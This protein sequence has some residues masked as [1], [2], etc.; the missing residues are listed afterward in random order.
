MIGYSDADFA[1]S[2]DSRKSTFGYIFKLADGAVSWRSVKQ[3]LT[4]TS[5]MEA[6]FVFC[7]E[8]SSHG[9]WL[10][11]FISGLS[12]TPQTRGSVDYPSTRGIQ[13]KVGLPDATLENR[14]ESP[15]YGELYPN[16]KPAYPVPNKAI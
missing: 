14:A 16:T 10:K 3:T 12:V 5:T 2:V 15:L 4:S 7:F 8:A 11:S 9:V 13:V 1:G 6:E